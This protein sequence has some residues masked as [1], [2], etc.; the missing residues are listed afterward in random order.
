MFSDNNI[1]LKRY[2]ELYSLSIEDDK[3]YFDQMF[4]GN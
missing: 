4:T 3:D 1:D 2:K